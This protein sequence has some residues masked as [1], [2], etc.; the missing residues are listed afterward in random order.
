MHGRGGRAGGIRVLVAAAIDERNGGELEY[1]IERER[2]D[3]RHGRS[4]A[5]LVVELTGLGGAAR[6]A[7]YPTFSLL[8]YE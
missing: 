2:W 1:G 4:A 8:K 7:P 6:M 5:S 3:H